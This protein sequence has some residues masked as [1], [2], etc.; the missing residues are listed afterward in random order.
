MSD[1]STPPDITDIINAAADE[2]S[3]A[4]SGISSDPS[5]AVATVPAELTLVPEP[6]VA[7]AMSNNAFASAFLPLSEETIVERE[8]QA[9]LESIQDRSISADVIRDQL[10]NRFSKAFTIEQQSR[11]HHKQH[12]QGQ[13]T[14]VIK[15]KA[16][17]EVTCAK[18]LLARH[19]IR[20]ISLADGRAGAELTLLGIYEEHGAERGM[21]LTSESPIV[22]LAYALKPSLTATA[23]ESLIKTLKAM[24]PVVS[25]TLSAHLIPV[26]NGIFNRE[27][28][29]LM[30][31]G[32]EYVFLSKS[33]VLY[34]A[35]AENPVIT[36][37]D[38]LPWDVVTWIDE[39]SDDEGVSELLWEIASATMR[40]GERW[41][42]AAFFHST[43]GN[44][45]KGTFCE[46]L[47]NLMGPDG[48]ASIPIAKFGEQFALAELI[49]ARSIIV[50]ENPVGAFSKD[51][52]DFKAVI[53]GD[54]FTLERKYK[55]PLSV[56]FNGMVI[57]CVNDFPKSRD[58]SASYTRRQLFVPFR[59][60]FGGDGVERKYIKVDYLA[61]QDVLEYVM[62]KALHMDHTK[63]SNPVACQELLAQFQRENNP[64]RDFWLELQD[65][66][67]WDLLPTNF[68]YD[69]FIAWFRKN[70]PSGIPVNR[71][72]F[73]GQL[74]EVVSEADEWD[75]SDPQKKNRPGQKMVSPEVLIAEYD[76]KE[77]FN[78]G[79]SGNDRVRKSGFVPTRANYRGVVRVSRRA[80]AVPATVP[81]AAVADETEE[82]TTA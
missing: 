18:V 25:K 58:K 63:F 70:H 82:V 5:S 37:P 15:P 59:K 29:E 38:G 16:L 4:A 69:L 20:A 9:Y 46:L 74:A 22:R 14:K 75:F 49:H 12:H 11:D 78:T 47:R 32:P 77:W 51:L 44:N 1:Q 79:Y 60:W 76:L 67:V 55:N 54:T 73:T 52:G 42:Q 45:G 35:N 56:S 10:L 61:R 23:A 8:T 33:P 80:A 68:L 64:V 72:E 3:A 7:P 27:T 30:D 2:A 31:F 43:K 13:H 36:Q 39:L 57:Q 24:A 28:R 19:K 71:N 21:Y 17:D 34:N 6:A 65:E 81:G 48:H 62:L 41:D 50:D 66:F 26:A 53:T 40:P